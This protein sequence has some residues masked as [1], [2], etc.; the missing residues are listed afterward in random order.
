MEQGAL[1]NTAACTWMSHLCRYK[2]PFH[3]ST[4]PRSFENI[5]CSWQSLNPMHFSKCPIC[6]QIWR[7]QAKQNFF[8]IFKTWNQKRRCFRWPSWS[9][10]L[11]ESVHH[12]K[13]HL[14]EPSKLQE[15]CVYSKFCVSRVSFFKTNYH[16]LIMFHCEKTWFALVLKR[17]L[18]NM[19]LFIW[20][21]ALCFWRR[22]KMCLCLC[23]WRCGRTQNE[24]LQFAI[25]QHLDIDKD[26]HK[27]GLTISWV[28]LGKSEHGWRVQLKPSINSSFQHRVAT[29]A[30][31]H[32]HSP[33]HPRWSSVNFG[34]SG[35]ARI[36][37]HIFFYWRFHLPCFPCHPYVVLKFRLLLTTIVFWNLPW[38]SLDKPDF[39]MHKTSDT[40]QRSA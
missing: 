36:H 10:L 1:V 31:S 2:V 16:R 4:V 14:H 22:V 30:S 26:I 11:D 29:T 20:T 27:D 32:S 8:K 9:S 15:L 35:H 24:F 6:M 28:K 23:S 37:F 25:L 21:L 19:T 17:S 7:V 34:E 40:A 3:R 38:T 12:L 5:R 39:P 13:Q 33:S 18:F